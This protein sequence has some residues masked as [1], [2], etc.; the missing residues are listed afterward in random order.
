MFSKLHEPVSGFT[1]LAGA[2]SALLGLAALL[3]WSGSVT[4]RL[5]SLGVYG[6]SLFLMFFTSSMYHLLPVS[7][8]TRSWLRQL[9][10]AAIYLLIAGTYTPFCVNAFSGFWQTGFL[11]IIWGLAAI[12]IGVKIFT[13]HAPRWITAGIYV[14]MGWLSL[15][16]IREITTSL[17]ASAITWMVTG[18]VI[19]TLGAGV[20]IT[21]KFNFRPG[22][23][24]FHEVWHIFVLLGAGAHFLAVAFM[25]NGIR[26]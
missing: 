4:S 26:M 1:H 14:V 17:P 22:I 8:Q 19:Y 7:P 10:H 6:V 24:G 16:A 20:Y 13:I 21:R 9:D 3:A 25:L 11:A 5:V 18:G 2:F 15:F 12:G 23:F